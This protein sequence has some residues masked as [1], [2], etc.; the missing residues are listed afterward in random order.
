ME[1]D[2]ASGNPDPYGPISICNL[3]AWSSP[4]PHFSASPKEYALGIVRSLVS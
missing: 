2:K 1:R 3:T 4:P